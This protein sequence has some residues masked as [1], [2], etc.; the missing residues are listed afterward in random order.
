MTVDMEFSNVY[1]IY[2]IPYIAEKIMCLQVNQ[3]HIFDA[4]SL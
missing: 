3:Q 1:V 2:L 4:F